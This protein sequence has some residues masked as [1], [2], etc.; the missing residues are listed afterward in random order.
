MCRCD[1]TTKYATAT[2]ALM[3]YWAQFIWNIASLLVDRM[4]LSAAVASDK[5]SIFGCVYGHRRLIHGQFAA[6]RHGIWN[7]AHWPAKIC[8]RKLW[9]I[10]MST[11][12]QYSTLRAVNDSKKSNHNKNIQLYRMSV[13][14]DIWGAIV[15]IVGFVAFRFVRTS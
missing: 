4:Y 13:S 10:Y 11:A 6:V 8:C 9:S 5:Y 2:R 1:C 15:H 14:T 12:L 7:L 3:G